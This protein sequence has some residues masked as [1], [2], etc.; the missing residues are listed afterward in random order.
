M[1]PRN[2][3]AG[4]AQRGK[5]GVR[6]D[7]PSFR[8]EYLSLIHIFVVNLDDQAVGSGGHGGQGQRL[9]Q[10]ADAGGMAGVYDCL[11]YTSRCV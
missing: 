11:L 1:Y 6:Q 4:G 9:Y 5:A 7:H 3:P 8:R 10:P 2:A